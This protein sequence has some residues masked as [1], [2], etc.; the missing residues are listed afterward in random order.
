MSDQTIDVFHQAKQHVNKPIARTEPRT[1]S[2]QRQKRTKTKTITAKSQQK[3]G[4]QF[5]FQTSTRSH[6]QPTVDD[7]S[8]SYSSIGPYA[9]LREQVEAKGLLSAQ[10]P[11]VSRANE[12]ITIDDDSDESTFNGYNYAYCCNENPSVYPIVPLYAAYENSNAYPKFQE[13]LSNTSH[14]NPDVST[15]QSPHFCAMM[16]PMFGKGIP[17]MNSNY[18]LPSFDGTPDVILWI[19]EFERAFSLHPG[20]TSRNPD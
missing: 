15:T 11:F 9:T 2:T 16:N 17:V 20:A 19:E 18:G 14:D 1:L 8:Y 12:S 7:S 10:K 5:E 6:I 3:S 13:S 4:H